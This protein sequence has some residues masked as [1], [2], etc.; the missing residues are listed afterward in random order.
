MRISSCFSWD[1]SKSHFTHQV[2]YIPACCLGAAWTPRAWA[3]AKLYPVDCH[4]ILRENLPGVPKDLPGKA[5]PKTATVYQTSH[6]EKGVWNFSYRFYQ[7]AQKRCGC[8][9]M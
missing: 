4:G 3:M 5:R 8:V 1:A 6:F 9:E 7:T 2:S